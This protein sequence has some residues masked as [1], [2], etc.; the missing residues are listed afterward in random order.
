MNPALLTVVSLSIACAVL[1]VFI[2]LRRWSFIGE[3]ISHSTFGGAGLAWLAALVFPAVEQSAFPLVALMVVL[4]CGATAIVIGLLTRRSTVHPDAAIGIFLVASMAFGFLAQNIYFQVRRSMPS[5]WDVLL[6][7]RMDAVSPTFAQAAAVLSAAVVAILWLLR[8]E[9][10][11]CALSPEAAETSGVNSGFIHYLSL[12]LAAVLI[13]IGVRVAGSVL[14]PALLILPGTIGL[15]LSRRLTGVFT[16]A[17]IVGIV[18]ALA[19]QGVHQWWAFMP[20]GPMLVLALFAQFL[21]A[22][23][24]KRLKRT[25]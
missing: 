17:V 19:A 10:I 9:M 4:F 16:I 13:M 21:A 3:G 1:S 25:K 24:F 22:L 14:V 20:M 8:K 12:M 2:V 18:A 6:F 5:G 15:Q 11:Y 7:G 23:V